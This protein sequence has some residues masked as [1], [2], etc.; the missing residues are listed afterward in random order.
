MYYIAEILDHPSALLNILAMEECDRNTDS[1]NNNKNKIEHISH[2]LQLFVS[3]C[4]SCIFNLFTANRKILMRYH[5]YCVR[6]IEPQ[7]QQL[8]KSFRDVTC[9]LVSLKAA[10]KQRRQSGREQTDGHSRKLLWCE[11]HSLK[12]DVSWWSGVPITCVMFGHPLREIESPKNKW[13][14]SAANAGTS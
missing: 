3:R 1:Q 10:H 12:I 14:L 6:C 4:W 5:T 11:T 8:C 7:R 2:L 13:Q 9:R